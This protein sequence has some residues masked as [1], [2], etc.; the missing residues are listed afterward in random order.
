[1]KKRRDLPNFG[2]IEKRVNVQRILDEANELGLLNFEGYNDINVSA[3]TTMSKFVEANQVCRAHFSGSDE[4]VM[5]SD[6]YRQLYLTEFNAEQ[7]KD[8]EVDVEST[9]FSFRKRLERLNKGSGVYVPE[10]DERN[11][12]KR[13]DFVK[14][15]I[16]EIL[17][18]FKDQ[19]TRVRFALMQPGFD[20]EPHID[21]DTDYIVRYHIP[22]ITN[23]KC[24]MAIKRDGAWSHSHFPADGR[25]YFFNAG[26]A[27]TAYN[28]GE[29]I[30]LHL[31]VDC[32][33][34]QDLET[35]DEFPGRST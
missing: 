34:Q 30:R 2:T 28:H 24:G 19:V 32:H 8:A 14:G 33:G 31:V 23:D 1:M 25:I 16:A 15:Y 5:N 17:D 35:L 6:H 26:F 10:A 18:S 4:E 22:L 29:T 21:Y 27:H 20:I 11:Y 13:R 12:T 3:G 9:I 7:A